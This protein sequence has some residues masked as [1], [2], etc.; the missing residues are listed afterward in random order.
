MIR[1]D[2]RQVVNE[3]STETGNLGL[4]VWNDDS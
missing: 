4:Y 1:K 2:L 3:L